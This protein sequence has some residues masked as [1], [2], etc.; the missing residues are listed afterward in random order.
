MMK[1]FV[2]LEPSVFSSP[3]ADVSEVLLLLLVSLPESLVPAWL[4]MSPLDVELDV[5]VSPVELLPKLPPILNALGEL[6]LAKPSVM[7]LV[8]A[9]LLLVWSSDIS[10]KAVAVAAIANS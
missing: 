4:L 10:E 8:T 2:V 9:S 6:K 3:V 1:G 7:F 5:P